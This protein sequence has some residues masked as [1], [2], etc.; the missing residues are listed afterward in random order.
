VLVLPP[1]NAGSAGICLHL[2]LS[3]VCSNLDH[4]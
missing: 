1:G 3:T 4:A 2:Y